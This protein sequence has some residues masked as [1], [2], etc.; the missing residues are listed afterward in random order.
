MKNKALIIIALTILTVACTK[1]SNVASSP[2]SSVGKGGSLARFTIVGNYMYL[3]D[4]YSL[5]TYDISLGNAPSL[6]GQ[7]TVGFGIETIYP[8][9]ENLFIG[10]SDGMY[11]YSVK[12]PAKPVLV[13][14]ARH[15]RSC[16]PVVANDT[17]AFVTLRG[18]S[19]CGP[20]QDGLYIYNIKNVL[21]PAQIKL[22]PLTKS[23]GLGLKDTTLF[24]CREDSGL[25]VVNV[26]NPIA[27][28]HVKDIKDAIYYDVI[29]LDDIL[30]CMVKTGIVLYDIKDVNNI[31][32]INTISN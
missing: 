21:N 4:N 20:A 18:S 8:Y 29:P 32:L 31:K 30:V 5:I 28:V 7:T 10:S 16:D 23:G 1:D 14:S 6:V 12:D 13:G 9:K 27:P 15:V 25:A 26:K 22:M 3:A 2:G 11:V 17:I 19:R 24:I